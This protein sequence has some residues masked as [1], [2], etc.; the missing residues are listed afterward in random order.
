MIQTSVPF[1]QWAQWAKVILSF[2]RPLSLAERM[3]RKYSPN[4]HRRHTTE[5]PGVILFTASVRKA[6]V[7]EGRYEMD[8]LL[9]GQDLK[10]TAN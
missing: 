9:N 4:A 2:K 5:S 7:T 10:R 6:V 3:S 1:N 8:T